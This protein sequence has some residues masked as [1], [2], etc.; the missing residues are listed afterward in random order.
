MLLFPFLLLATKCL[1][2]FR[3]VDTS[4]SKFLCQS[5]L[6]VGSEFLRVESK[7]QQIVD[8]LLYCCERSSRISMRS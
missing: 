2:S 7:S 5:G 8:T 6:G 4:A 1:Q 3:A